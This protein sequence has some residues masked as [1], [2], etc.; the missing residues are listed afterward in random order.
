MQ[1]T[2]TGTRLQRNM[3]WR[4]GREREKIRC[5]N[6][7]CEI[8]TSKAAAIKNKS[9]CDQNQLNTIKHG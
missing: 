7:E 5:V 9:Y 1:Q 4:V 6:W 2:E 3:Y 8:R